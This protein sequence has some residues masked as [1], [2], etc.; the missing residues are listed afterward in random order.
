MAKIHNPLPVILPV[1]V[2]D[3]WLDPAADGVELRGLL[4]PLPAQE[5]EAYEVS[6]FVNCHGTI[7]RSVCET[8]RVGRRIEALRNV[9]A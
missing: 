5:L 2:R 7:R 1:E 3:Q 9:T 8:G 6:K 4:V